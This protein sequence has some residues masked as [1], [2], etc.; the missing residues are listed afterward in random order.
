MTGGGAGGGAALGDGLGTAFGGGGSRGAAFAGG[1]CARGA[2]GAAEGGGDGGVGGLKRGAIW[3][4]SGPRALPGLSASF[5]GRNNSG[6]T[7]H[8]RSAWRRIDSATVIQ[9]RGTFT[10]VRVLPGVA[11]NA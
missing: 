4:E 10:P 1:R 7:C 9:I 3:T 11:D 8:S 5:E 2:D 6:F